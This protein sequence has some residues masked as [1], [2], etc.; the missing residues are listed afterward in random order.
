[1]ASIGTRQGL[2]A[3][4]I[5]PV[6]SLWIILHLDG[7]AILKT[8]PAKDRASL[9]W[10]ER[11]GRFT[12]ALKTGCGCLNPAGTGSPVRGSRLSFTFTGP[13]AF[14]FVSEILLP[15]ELLFTRGKNEV[16]SAIDAL[17]YP[18]L[19]SGHGTTPDREKGE[20]IAVRFALLIVYS[21]SR[22]LFFRYLLRARAAFTRFFS[23]GFK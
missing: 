12:T 7:L 1:L 16:S 13:A 3:L 11:N 15:I 5:A 22:R 20:A 6:K 14:G 23:P 8:V 21:G 19:E 9:R 2:A 4:M 18:I 17:Q 10:F